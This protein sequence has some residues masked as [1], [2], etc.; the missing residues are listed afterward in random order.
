MKKYRV[1]ISLKPTM[2]E[3]EARNEGDA[4]L[5]ASTMVKDQGA[6][7]YRVE[8]I[9]SAKELTTIVRCKDCIHRDPEDKKC[10][11]GMFERQGNIFPVKDDYFCAYGESKQSDNT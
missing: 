6:W 7:R 11:C 3:V 4:Y 2:Y 9:E 5:Q 8:E 1:W 10:D